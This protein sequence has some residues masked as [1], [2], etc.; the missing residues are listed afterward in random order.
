MSQEIIK[1]YSN[2]DLTV[3]WKPKK[4]IHSE[5]CVKTLPQVYDPNARPWIQPENATIEALQAQ[6]D[7]CPSGGVDL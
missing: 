1:E 4:C 7:Q 3:V 2:G 5:I 6:I